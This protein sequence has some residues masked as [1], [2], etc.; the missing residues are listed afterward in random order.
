MKDKMVIL[1]SMRMQLEIMGCRK[2]K[3][4]FNESFTQPILKKWAKEK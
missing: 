4:E 2:Q 1:K 3:P